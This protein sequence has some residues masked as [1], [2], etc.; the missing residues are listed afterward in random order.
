MVNDVVI[1]GSAV[2]GAVADSLI[3]IVLTVYFLVDFPRIRT[4]AATSRHP[5]RR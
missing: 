3:V 1:A 5:H 2:F 4:S